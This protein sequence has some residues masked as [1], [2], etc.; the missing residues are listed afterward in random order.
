MKNKIPVFSPVPAAEQYSSVLSKLSIEF[1]AGLRPTQIFIRITHR[2]LI[3]HCPSGLLLGNIRRHPQV[4]IVLHRGGGCPSP[5]M[6]AH[7]HRFQQKGLTVPSL[8]DNDLFCSGTAES[9]F[10]RRFRPARLQDNQIRWNGFF[11]SDGLERIIMAAKHH[12]AVKSV[13]RVTLSA[14]AAAINPIGRTDVNTSALAVS[15]GR[16]SKCGNK[17]CFS[18]AP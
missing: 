2:E 1:Y 7:S 18:P 12:P 11:R 8:A 16:D 3:I 10:C 17:R 6:T 5:I 9:G 13:V 4:H 15:C 14:T